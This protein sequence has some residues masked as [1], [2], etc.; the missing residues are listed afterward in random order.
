MSTTSTPTTMS[1]ISPSTIS[2]PS[3]VS[4]VIKLS[5]QC[6]TM[7]NKL[8]NVFLSSAFRCKWT[9]TYFDRPEVGL[10]GIADLHRWSVM[11][12]LVMARGLLEYLKVRGGRPVFED[13]QAPNQKQNQMEFLSVDQNGNVKF[14]NIQQGGQTSTGNVLPAVQCL[15]LGKRAIYDFVLNLYKA[16]C[17][18]NDPLL[19]DF[20]EV[21]YIRPVANI[22]QKLGVL[23]SQAEMACRDTTVGIYQFNK[24][25]EKHLFEIMAYNKLVR[26][27]KW[28]FF[29]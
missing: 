26:P 22:N 25:I 11:S 17:D 20:L 3:R 10:F 13:I 9:S 1:S 14:Q 18:S 16:A 19:T 21:N 4:S 27:D 12:D 23:Q 2:S 7:I 29:V 15:I 5:N 6:E 8:I 28:S 24:D